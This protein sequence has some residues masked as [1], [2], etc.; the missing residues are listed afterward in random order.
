MSTVPASTTICC[1]RSVSV[2]CAAVHHVLRAHQRAAAPL[3]AVDHERHLPGPLARVGLPTVDHRAGRGRPDAPAPSRQEDHGGKRCP[4]GP[5]TWPSRPASGLLATA[6]R[7]CRTSILSPGPGTRTQRAGGA[8]AIVG[9]QAAPIGRWGRCRRARPRGRRR[10]R[11]ATAGRRSWSVGPTTVPIAAPASRGP[12]AW[13]TRTVGRRSSALVAAGVG[14]DG[15]GGAVG[16]HQ[17]D[18]EV[19]RAA[20]G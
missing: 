2:Q 17:P 3:A 15:H 20:G 7:I 1:G 13:M 10:S 4:S 11:R 5:A 6:G 8:L 14:Q 16:R 12:A 19:G 18:V 9:D